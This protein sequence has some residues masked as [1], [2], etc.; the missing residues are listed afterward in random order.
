MINTTT[1]EK[2]NLLVNIT[3]NEDIKKSSKDAIV[4]INKLIDELQ[5]VILAKDEIDPEYAGNC[6][7]LHELEKTRAT[8][9]QMYFNCDK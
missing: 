8:L 9:C 5:K 2:N 3:T 1:T 7:A 6:I 4:S